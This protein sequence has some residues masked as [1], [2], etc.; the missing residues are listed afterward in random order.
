MSCV[1]ELEDSNNYS[2]VQKEKRDKTGVKVSAAALEVLLQVTTKQRE[3]PGSIST[4]PGETITI[5][6][7]M[8]RGS[9][10]NPYTSWYWQKLGSASVFIWSESS[11]TPSGIPQR[12]TGSVD[13]SSK[14]MHLTISNVQS[15]D[16]ADNYWRV[17][18]NSIGRFIFG[19][20]TKLNLDNPRVPTVSLL[21]PSSDQIAAKD[22]ATLVCLV[23][24]FN[25][26]AAEIEWTVDGSV[27]GNGV[28]T[29]RIQQEADNTFSVSSY[30]TLSASE[31]NSHEL[32]SCLVKHEALANPLKRSISRSSCV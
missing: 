32:Y 18:L 28:E 23:S 20:G 12:F 31:W 8:S 1:R 6:C 26:G 9:I 30:L 24:G 5:T 27:R 13:S 15:E 16:P 4:S 17:W 11:G 2:P 22:T 21:P 25:P 29:S 14:T 3:Q 7:T 19:R 10:G